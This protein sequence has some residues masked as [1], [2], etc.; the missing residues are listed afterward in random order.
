MNKRK[1]CVS[2]SL[3]C[4]WKIFMSFT[5]AAVCS[6][7][8]TWRLLCIVYRSYV[9][10]RI[11]HYSWKLWSFFAVYIK[12]MFILLEFMNSWIFNNTWISCCLFFYFIIICLFFFTWDE[13][14]KRFLLFNKSNYLLLRFLYDSFHAKRLLRNLII[15]LVIA[16]Q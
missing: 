9:C 7:I 2:A 5:T 13:R 4:G 12:K 10:S 6:L 3:K 1:I 14:E 11:Y 15:F 8:S 16:M